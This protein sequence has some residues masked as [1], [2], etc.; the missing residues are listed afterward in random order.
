M[1]NLHASP[2]F[3]SPHK[4]EGTKACRNSLSGID[5]IVNSNK[6][7][8]STGNTDSQHAE[9]F[10]LYY[11]NMTIVLSLNTNFEKNPYLSG[12]NNLIFL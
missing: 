8:L 9:D 11:D 2:Y 1:R 12:E 5:F 6:H 7:T 4:T 3:S 10:D